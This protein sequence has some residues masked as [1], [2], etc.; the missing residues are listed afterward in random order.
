MNTP[1]KKVP[2]GCRNDVMSNLKQ[3][4][5]CDNATFVPM[6]KLYNIIRIDVDENGYDRNTF[7]MES[8]NNGHHEH[9]RLSKHQQKKLDN[10]CSLDQTFSMRTRNTDIK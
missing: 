6:G 4:K 8:M 1:L 3:K 10:I 5:K 7:M 9:Y 2:I